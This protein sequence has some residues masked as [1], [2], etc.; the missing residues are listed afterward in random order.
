[1]VTARVNGPL[2]G[3]DLSVRQ[4]N[5]FMIFHVALI[6]NRISDAVDWCGLD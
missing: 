1:M 2:L 6:R 3:R 5:V 4:Q